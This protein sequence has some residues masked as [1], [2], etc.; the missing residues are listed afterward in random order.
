MGERH[1]LA[2]QSLTSGSRHQPWFRFDRGATSTGAGRL[3]LLYSRGDCVWKLA[4]GASTSLN[5][6]MRTTARTCGKRLGGW[7]VTWTNCRVC[8]RH[9]ELTHREP[10]E[11][12]P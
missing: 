12:P 1:E 5:F 6:S 10:K 3:S 11:P 4:G 2:R 7:S 8:G 9:T